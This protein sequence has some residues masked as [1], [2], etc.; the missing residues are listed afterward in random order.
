MKVSKNLIRTVA[1]ALLL[2]LCAAPALAQRGKWWQDERFQ[3]EL[4][5]TTEQVTRLE[6]IFQKHQPK[7]REHMKALEQAE[8]QLSQLIEKGDDASVMAHMGV[9]EAARAELNKTRT[10]ML[11]RM[12]RSLT[13]DQWAKFTALAS[14]RTRRGRGPDRAPQ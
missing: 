10:L 4:G 3:R 2:A 14:E 12:R 13:A 1:A 11:L 9:V 8:D 7:L 6:E 5:L